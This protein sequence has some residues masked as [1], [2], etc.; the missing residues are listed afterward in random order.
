LLLGVGV[1]VVEDKVA[2]VAQVDLERVQVY[3]LPQERLTRL[4]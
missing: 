3:P 4:L 2:V 1:A